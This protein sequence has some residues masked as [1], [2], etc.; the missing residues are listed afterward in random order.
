[1]TADDPFLNVPVS[2]Y[3]SALDQI[4]LPYDLWEI[5]RLGLPGTNDFRAY[6]VVIYRVAEFD[7][8][9]LPTAQQNA[10]QAYLDGGGALFIGSMELL[11]RIGDVPFRRNGLH[12]DSFDE[13]ATVPAIAGVDNDPI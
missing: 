8:N 6:R 9:A 13:D 5:S 11:S 1:M 10:L 2:G 7:Q 4:G 3:T 12:V